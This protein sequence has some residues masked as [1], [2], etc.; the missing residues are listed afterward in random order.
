MQLY[1]SNERSEAKNPK[2]RKLQ[3]CFIFF[4]QRRMIIK[5][6]LLKENNSLGLH[7]A[8]GKGSKRGDIGIFVAGISEN[9]PAFR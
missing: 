4:F 2:D 6:H 1:F 9:G 5:L 8:G 7:I 3:N